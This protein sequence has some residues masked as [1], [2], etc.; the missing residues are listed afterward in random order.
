MLVIAHRGASSEKPENTLAAYKR[1]IVM[2]ADFVEMDVH[3]S[4]DGVPICY[5][6][7]FLRRPTSD[8][9]PR[10]SDCTVQDLKNFAVGEWE[11]PTLAEVLALDF[12]HSGLMVEL[13]EGSSRLAQAVTQQLRRASVS[14]VV[15]GSFSLDMMAELSEIWSPQFLIGIVEDEDKIAS[16]LALH[17]RILAIDVAL[18][19]PERVQGL[20]S[21]GVEVWVWT[22]DDP[23]LS[24]SLV[25]R[26]VTGIITNNP[27][28]LL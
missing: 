26:G 11:I 5:H 3:L 19:N 25:Q 2:G 23:I 6:D 10:I 21:R 9:P 27:R 12:A 14:D 20:V 28:E 8:K 7:E 13:K 4:Q 15:L 24:R 1:A 16:H 22:V 18:A 17:P